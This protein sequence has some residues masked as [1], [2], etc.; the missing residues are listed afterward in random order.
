[1][2]RRHFLAAAGVVV[3]SGRIL[4]EE[5]RPEKASVEFRPYRPAKTL[6]P[7]TCVTPHDDFYLQTFFDVYP[8]SP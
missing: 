2:R 6:C 4:A 3:I 5:K 8:F 1:M 7:V